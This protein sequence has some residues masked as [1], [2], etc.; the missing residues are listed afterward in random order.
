MAI[1]GIITIGGGEW[2]GEGGGGGGRAGGGL[3]VMGCNR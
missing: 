3:S 1:M 2:R